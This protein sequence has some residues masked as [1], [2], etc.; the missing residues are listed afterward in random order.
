MAAKRRGSSSLISMTENCAKFTA[1][2]AGGF[3][4]RNETLTYFSNG[5][6]KRAARPH[7]RGL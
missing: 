7:A 4:L 3:A 1:S 6:S 2:I 5:M